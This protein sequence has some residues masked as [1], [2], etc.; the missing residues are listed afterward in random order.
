[1]CL[2]R[3]SFYEINRL[4]K[5]NSLESLVTNLYFNEILTTKIARLITIQNKLSEKIYNKIQ[6]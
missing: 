4:L 5:L 3:K 1:M 2:N 6:S